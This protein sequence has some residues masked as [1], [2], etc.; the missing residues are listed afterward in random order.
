MNKRLKNF[1]AS[2]LAVLAVMAPNELYSATVTWTGGGTSAN[3][4]SNDNWG[5]V[6]YART[7]DDLVFAGL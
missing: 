1:A 2:L 5:G 3:W 7:G 6:P 4:R